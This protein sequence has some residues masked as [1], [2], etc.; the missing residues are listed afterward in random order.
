[1]QGK[2]SCPDII[3]Y[4]LSVT[5]SMQ[6]CFKRLQSN[7]VLDAG[8]LLRS[9]IPEKLTRSVTTRMQPQDLDARRPSPVRTGTG[10]TVS[11][12]TKSHNNLINVSVQ[13]PSR[14]P[15]PGF[16]PPPKPA[17]LRVASYNVRVDHADDRGTIHDW[18]LRRRFVASTILSLQ[19]D[20]VA[21]QEPSQIQAGQIEADL[22]PEWGVAVGPC[23]PDAWAAAGPGGPNAQARDGNGLAY[24]R[25]RLTLLET[26]SFWLG[27]SPEEPAGNAGAWGGSQYLRTCHVSYLRD[28]KTS[29]VL[30]V[31]SA[32]F[33]HHGD[34][35][36]ESVRVRARALGPACRARAPPRHAHSFHPAT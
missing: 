6:Q 1:M 23:D 2:R 12:A 15:P 25:A 27:P 7:S 19:A 35:S 28:K 20:I 16:F 13:E 9:Q 33:D 14:G 30:A 4:L 8:R 3:C 31:F 29:V 22:G 17:V 5:C 24:R 10:L 32:H 26:S 21:L 36:Q 18:P 11:S 34:D